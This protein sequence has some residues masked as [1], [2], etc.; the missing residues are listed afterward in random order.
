MKL[1]VTPP[2]LQEA[3]DQS[4]M[5]SV[6]ASYQSLD[7]MVHTDPYQHVSS[8]YIDTY[9]ILVHAFK[10]VG[11]QNRT[12]FQAFFSLTFYNYIQSN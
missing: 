9:W 4:S 1:R 3:N 5:S 8:Q 2:V 6:P 12:I 11:K 10:K 7:K